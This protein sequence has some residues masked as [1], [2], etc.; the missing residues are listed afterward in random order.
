[1]TS[2][3]S[4]VSHIE[5]YDS[6]LFIKGVS[7]DSLGNQIAYEGSSEIEPVFVGGKL[8]M[9]NFLGSNMKY[10]LLAQRGNISGKVLCK[11]VVEKNGE[12]NDV[13]AIIGVHP[14]LDKEAIRVI[15]SMTKMW[16]PGY[17]N[18]RPVRVY[19]TMPISFRLE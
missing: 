4:K 19:Y 18:G 12:I 3:S 13:K 9:Y 10:P 2:F 7:T 16:H 11:F 6:G 14:E 1:I 17:Q 15:S 5:K 8:T